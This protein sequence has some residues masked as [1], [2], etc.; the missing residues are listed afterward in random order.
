MSAASPPV[1][2]LWGEDPYLLR[3]AAHVVLDGF[4]VTEVDGGES[5]AAGSAEAGSGISA[6]SRRPA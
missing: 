3:E 2:L 1:V 6:C 4:D 5:D